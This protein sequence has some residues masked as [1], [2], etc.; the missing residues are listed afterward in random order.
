MYL[1]FLTDQI[2]SDLSQIQSDLN[3][4]IIRS[5][6][7]RLNSDTICFDPNLVQIIFDSIRSDP[8]LI[9]IFSF[10]ESKLKITIKTHLL[11]IQ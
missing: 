1:V 5:D 2:R 8:N 9:Q 11:E 10:N 4:Y 6:L 3:F 7:I